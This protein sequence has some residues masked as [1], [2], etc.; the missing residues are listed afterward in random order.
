MLGFSV[1]ETSSKSKISARN[2]SV[3]G[4]SWCGIEEFGSVEGSDAGESTL[5]SAMES[6][7]G[8]NV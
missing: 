8:D 2:G 5:A 3:A 1:S 6:L 7:I 4:F